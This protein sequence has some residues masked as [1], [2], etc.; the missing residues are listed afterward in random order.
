MNSTTTHKANVSTTNAS[1][2]KLQSTTM[3]VARV[4]LVAIFILSALS[5]LGA[6][7]P[8]MGYMQA[9]G[10]PGALIYPT[11]AFEIA[12]GVLILIGLKVRT[13]A[14][15]LAGF[16]LVTAAIFHRNFGN[17]IE[18]IM[19]LKNVSMAGGFLLLAAAGGG[20][21]SLDERALSKP[22]L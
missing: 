15:L 18:M 21:L 10:V 4:L 3:L 16:S 19:F 5:K 9:M 22:R 13:T 2:F 14:V 12:A 6:I 20:A 1:A 8:T 7:Q 17:Q 11:I